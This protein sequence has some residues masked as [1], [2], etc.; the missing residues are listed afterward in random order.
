MD[1][2]PRAAKISGMR[3]D[4]KPMKEY[5][6]MIYGATGRSGQLIARR[7]V[8]QGLRP[9]L[10]GRNTKAIQELA[11]ELNLSWRAFEVADWKRFKEEVSKVN[12]LVNAAG[13]FLQFSVLIA[14]ACLAVHTHYFDLSNEIPSLTAVYTLDAEAKEKD[15]LLL[16]GL[17]FSPAASNFLVEYLHTLLPGADSLDIALQPFMRTQAIGAN[18]NIFESVM[19]GVFRR[20]GGVLERYWIGGPL[21]QV[22]LPNGVR[23]LVPAALGDLEAAYRCTKIPNIMTHVVVDILLFD[24]ILQKT[25]GAAN[26][27]PRETQPTAANGNTKGQGNPN[28]GQS[29]V[30]ARMSKAGKNALEG[31]LHLGEGYDF[32][33][34]MVVA[35]V[36]RLVEE[37]KLS[38]GAHTPATALGADFIL[39][40]PD[41]ERKVRP[42]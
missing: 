1:F 38:T 25:T 19:G 22:T 17:A 5:Q 7:A 36:S 24:E 21:A 6:W 10:A 3:R 30:W 27:G 40:L 2:E 39:N 20:R 9:I 23:T 42:A 31:W 28:G 4:E 33:A 16:P 34:A 32:T 13:P 35:V 11:E 14:E 37:R 8:S 26:Y 41:V 15:L 29:L 18:L 12:L